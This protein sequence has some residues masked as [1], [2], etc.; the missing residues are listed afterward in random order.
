MSFFN[1]FNNISV[2]PLVEETA[3]L[4]E[5]HQPVTDKLLSHNVVSSISRHE[6]VN[7]SEE[8]PCMHYCILSC[9]QVLIT[10]YIILNLLS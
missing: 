4:R 7:F 8:I 10:L 5:N 9:L 1:G 2:I 6:R 3:V